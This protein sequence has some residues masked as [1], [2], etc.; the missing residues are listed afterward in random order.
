MQSSVFVIEFRMLR[1]VAKE[2]HFRFKIWPCKCLLCL[3]NL[4]FAYQV[5][6]GSKNTNVYIFLKIF[7]IYF[8]IVVEYAQ[9]K[10]AI[11]LILK[12]VSLWR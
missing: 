1:E 9:H 10:I 12:C 7:I 8:V 2:L 3:W 4:G 6:K 5:S 11:L